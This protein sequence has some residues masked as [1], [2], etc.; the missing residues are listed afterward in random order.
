MQ[1]LRNH[2]IG[3]DQD[4]LTL[5]SDFENG[6]EMW[7]GKGEREKRLRVS[8]SEPYRRPPAVQI[9][10]SMW[11]ID[12]ST[13]VRADVSAQSITEEGFDAV[14]STWGDTRVAR[15]RVSWIAIGELKDDDDWDLE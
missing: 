7:T 1:K 8:F 10:V 3:V 12:T 14:F 2:L 15:C 13:A 9:S 11:D 4:E 6:G 5:F